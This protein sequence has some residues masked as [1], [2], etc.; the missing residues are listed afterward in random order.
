MTNL[1]DI[2]N[3][4]LESYQENMDINDMQ[5]NESKLP[6]SDIKRQIIEET[7]LII[8]DRLVG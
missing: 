4:M 6:P 2:L 5:D 8:K 7:L 3:D 1:R